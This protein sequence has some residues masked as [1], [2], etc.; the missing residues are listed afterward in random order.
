M[1]I[2]KLLKLK[3]KYNRCKRVQNNHKPFSKQNVSLFP[4]YS[5][6][7]IKEKG[8]TTIERLRRKRSLK[9]IKT[10]NNH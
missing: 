9:N 2:E 1:N 10:Y 8:I 6:D 7:E 3:N 4:K 5:E